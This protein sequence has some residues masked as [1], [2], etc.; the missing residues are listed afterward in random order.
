MTSKN[1]ETSN[2]I[3]LPKI[4]VEELMCCMGDYLKYYIL[5]LHVRE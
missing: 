4:L 5:L 1:R 2:L 3:P